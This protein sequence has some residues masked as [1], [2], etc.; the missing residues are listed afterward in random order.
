MISSILTASTIVIS[1]DCPS[2]EFSG[3]AQFQQNFRIRKLGEI[4]LLFA[5]SVLNAAKYREANTS[6]THFNQ[7]LHYYTP[8]KNL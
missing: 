2:V 8:W 4:F 5:V 3:N 1:P 6:L 7:M